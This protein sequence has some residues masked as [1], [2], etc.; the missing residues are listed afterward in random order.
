MQKAI[1]FDMDGVIVDSEALHIEIKQAVLRRHGV[2]ISIEECLPYIGRSSRDFFRDCL[3]KYKLSIGLEKLVA[4]KHQAFLRAV[5]GERK[6]MPIAGVINL[7][8]YLRVQGY[9]LAVASSST[10]ANIE[11]FLDQ[12]AVRAEFSYLISGEKQEFSKPHPAIYQAALQALQL[13]PSQCLAIEDSLNGVVA[14]QRAG[15]AC[16][17]YYDRRYHKDSSTLAGA[18]GIVSS[19][20]QVDEILIEQIMRKKYAKM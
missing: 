20:S 13:P 16:L 15:L 3:Q 14:A 9:I 2:E 4:E 6:V 7:I 18:D 10:M 11:Y 1:I 17:A 5:R 12:L 8:R 19:M